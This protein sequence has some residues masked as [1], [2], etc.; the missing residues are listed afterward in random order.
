MADGLQR[1]RKTKLT[2]FNKRLNITRIKLR[3]RSISLAIPG[4]MCIR[5][6][7]MT[8]GKKMYKSDLPNVKL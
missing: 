8:L 3:K 7:S 2:N 1:T 4:N 5:T 6:L